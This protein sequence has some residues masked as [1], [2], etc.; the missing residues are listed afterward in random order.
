[1]HAQPRELVAANRWSIGVGMTRY[2]VVRAL[3]LLGIASLVWRD[4]EVSANST[5]ADT[6]EMSVVGKTLCEVK[7]SLGAQTAYRMPFAKDPSA[8]GFA[9]IPLH[10]KHTL[11]VAL[12]TMANRECPD[13]LASLRIEYPLHSRPTDTIGFN[14]AVLNEVYDRHKSYFAVFP[15]SDLE[16]ARASLAWSFDFG[17]RTFAAYRRVEN[18]YCANFIAD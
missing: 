9:A 5:Y 17:T 11:I 3:L 4:G 1:V 12:S 7:S 8:Y 14:C 18:V 6:Q 13:I 15:A 2:G 10:D 16:Y